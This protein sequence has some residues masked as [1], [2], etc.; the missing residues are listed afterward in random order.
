M[1]MTPPQLVAEAKAQIT[2]IDPGEAAPQ[3]ASKKMV[4]IDVREPA[5]FNAGSL[6]DAVNIPRGILEFQ[7]AEHPALADKDAN[8]LLYCKTG[9]RSALAAVSLHRMGY[10][11]LNSLLGGFDAWAASGQPVVKPSL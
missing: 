8:I 2:E 9:G 11:R 1:N 7:T 10:S 6:P 4:V 3:V 5:E